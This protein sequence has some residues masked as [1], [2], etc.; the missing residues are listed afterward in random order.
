VGDEDFAVGWV[1]ISG[2]GAGLLIANCCS[3]RRGTHWLP[4]RY[5]AFPLCQASFCCGLDGRGNRAMR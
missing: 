4:F 2:N 3:G 5:A 1:E